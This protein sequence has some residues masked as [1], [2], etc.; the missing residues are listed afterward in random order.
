MVGGSF[1]ISFSIFSE[2]IAHALSWSAIV[3][4]VVLS[5]S[6]H[7]FFIGSMAFNA[8]LSCTTSRGLILPTATFEIMRSKSPIKAMFC[9][10]NNFKSGCLKKNST[11]L[12]R[13]LIGFTSLRG[14]ANQRLSIRAPIGLMVLSI[15]SS[16]VFPPSFMVPYSSKFRTVNRSNH[17]NRSSSIRESWVICPVCWWWVWSK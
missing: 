10:S 7:A 12:S 11:T 5:A 9:S 1:E 3:F 13:S 16:S 15:M 14:N 17:T 6:E 8:T 2:I 4:N